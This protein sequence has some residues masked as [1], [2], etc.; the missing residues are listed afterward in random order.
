MSVNDAYIAA[1]AVTV[2]AVLRTRNIK[3][4]QQYPGIRLHD[5]WSWPEQCM[6]VTSCAA[7]SGGGGKQDGT[8][9]S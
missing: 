6:T 2:G 8:R 7:S 9:V 4:F 5:P 3:G 1:T